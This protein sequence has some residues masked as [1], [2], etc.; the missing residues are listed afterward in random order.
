MK[1]NIETLIVARS[2]VLL[3]GLGALLESL[4]GITSVKGI[5]ELANAYEWMKAHQPK[6]VLLDSD[7]LGNNSESALEKIRMMS[8]KTKRVLLV[9]EIQRVDLTPKFAEAILIKGISPSALTTTIIN[10]LSEKGDEYADSN[11]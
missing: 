5:R 1:Q 8:P 9:G 11:G 6:I 2:V 10:L 4:P 3:Q 7:V